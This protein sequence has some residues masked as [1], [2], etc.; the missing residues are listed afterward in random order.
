MKKQT[1][2]IPPERSLAR[3]DEIDIQSRLDV[4]FTK[5]GNQHYKDGSFESP[6]YLQEMPLVLVH[7]ELFNSCTFDDYRYELRKRPDARRQINER[8]RESREEDERLCIERDHIAFSEL[9]LPNTENGNRFYQ[10][11]REYGKIPRDSE[12]A[13]PRTPEMAYW[14]KT[15]SCFYQARA[16]AL[17]YCLYAVIPDPL[18]HPNGHLAE[19]LPEPTRR[20]IFICTKSTVAWYKLLKAGWKHLKDSMPTS[21]TTVEQLFL[22]LEKHDFE[23]AWKYGPGDSTYLWMSKDEQRYQLSDYRRLFCNKYWDTE[24]RRESFKTETKKF[25]NDLA[26]SG[27]SGSVRLILMKEYQQLRP[28]FSRYYESLNSQNQNAYIDDFYWR[29]GTPYK[30]DKSCKRIQVK[31]GQHPLGYFE[32]IWA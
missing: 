30:S 18:V 22:E 12:A 9:Y 17:A 28:A 14:L 13:I 3:L 4:M 1:F 26:K 10:I 25:K 24:G 21:I 2:S 16:I 20:N 5:P 27:L 31:A 23:L 29:K 7:E 8:L 15:L 19:I 32:W 11:A 6:E